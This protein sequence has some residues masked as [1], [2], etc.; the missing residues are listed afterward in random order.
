MQQPLSISSLDKWLVPPLPRKSSSLLKVP[1]ALTCQHLANN[2]QDVFF[3]LFILVTIA[4]LFVIRALQHKD[5]LGADGKPCWPIIVAK[6]SGN[7]SR[8]I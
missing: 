6:G 2:L 1:E 7:H 4:V 5:L 8:A 3:T